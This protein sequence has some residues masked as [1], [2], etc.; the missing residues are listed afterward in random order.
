MKT[1]TL[2]MLAALLL[3]PAAG[4]AAGRAAMGIC[5]GL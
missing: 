4:R 5:T 1:R 3:A 2:I